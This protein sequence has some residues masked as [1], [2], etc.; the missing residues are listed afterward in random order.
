MH[1]G[2]QHLP[3]LANKP[4]WMQKAGG[5]GYNIGK[6]IGSLHLPKTNDI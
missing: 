2:Q 1:G 4:A 3:S 5:I 6:L